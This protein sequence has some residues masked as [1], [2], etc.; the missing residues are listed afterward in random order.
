MICNQTGI[1][2]LQNLSFLC[3]KLLLNA[4]Q[5]F[6]DRLS[7]NHFTLPQPAYCLLS[8]KWVKSCRRPSSSTKP[9]QSH[10]SCLCFEDP[11][12]FNSTA[13][14]LLREGYPLAQ[15][16]GSCCSGSKSPWRIDRKDPEE[17]PSLGSFWLTTDAF[18]NHSHEN[19]VK[20]AH[21]W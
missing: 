20:Y 12:A 3:L 8:S 19:G 17:K 11:C 4:F 21:V 15:S 10:H 1:F 18:P 5:A 14:Y 9:L 6:M 7:A 2:S 13:T 16:N